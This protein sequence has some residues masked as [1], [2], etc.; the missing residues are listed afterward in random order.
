MNIELQKELKKLME[1]ADVF[2]GIHS[3]VNKS[4]IYSAQH[5]RDI[6]YGRRNVGSGK[7]SIKKVKILI[8]LYSKEIEKAKSKI[9]T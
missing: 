6:R 4:E 9:L 7:E 5:I 8:D 3:K 1:T 2:T